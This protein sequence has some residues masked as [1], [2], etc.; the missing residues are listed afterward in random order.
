[1]PRTTP[2][3]QLMTSKVHSLG[4]EATLSEVREL[5]RAERCHHVPILDRGRLAGIVSSRDLIKLLQGSTA[6]TPGEIDELLDRSRVADVM[7]RD[8]A[9]MGPEEDVGRAIDL[10]ADGHLHSVLVVNDEGRL[11]GIV[12]DTDLLAYLG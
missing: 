8:L 4:L 12:T 2:I 10:V 3:S 11:L 7:S 6:S 5:L 1:M 9:T